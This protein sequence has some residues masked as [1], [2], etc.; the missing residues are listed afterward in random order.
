LAGVAGVDFSAELDFATELGR[1]NARANA[2]RTGAL[3]GAERVRAIKGPD[4]VAAPVKL[5]T[6]R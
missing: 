6:A 3:Y 1:K 4:Y 2:G 5:S